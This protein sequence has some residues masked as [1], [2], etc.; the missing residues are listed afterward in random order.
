M[1]LP[2]LRL[3]LI[4]AIVAVLCAGPA[5]PPA[6]AHSGAVAIAVPATDITID[7]DLTDWPAEARWSPIDKSR[8]LD[9]PGTVLDADGQLSVAYAPSEGDLYV[10]IRVADDSWVLPE[11]STSWNSGDGCE[12][13]VDLLHKP[14][15]ERVAQFAVR[16]RIATTSDPG[17]V[18]EELFLDADAD[19]VE[20]ATGWDGERRVY[21]WRVRVVQKTD[22][23]TRLS[24][25]SVVG[26][27]AAVL[28]RDRDGSFS[29]SAWS[30]GHHRFGTASLGDVILAGPAA[31][32]GSLA[33]VAASST[34]RP[35]RRA[36]LWLEPTEAEGAWLVVAAD[37]D[38]RVHADLPVGRYRL[39]AVDPEASATPIEVAAGTAVDLGTVAIPPLRAKTVPLGPG[40][41]TDAPGHTVPAGAGQWRP[42]WRS[43]SVEDG[44]PDPT[45]TD[46]AQ[47]RAGN[48]W[49][50]TLAGV[51]RYDGLSFTTFTVRDGLPG[52]AASAVLADPQD[53]IWLSMGG[54]LNPGG[55][56]SCLANGR[57]TTYQSQDGLPGSRVLSMDQDGQG[58]LWLGMA[59]GLARLH[60]DSLSVYSWD[61]GLPMA[62]VYLV[63]RTADN[64]IWL[65][66]NGAVG[67]YDGS[68]IHLFTVQDGLPGGHVQGIA[69]TP[70]GEVWVGT[71]EG[72]ARLRGDRFVPLPRGEGSPSGFTASV[73]A[74]A[75]GSMWVGTYEGAHRHADGR[76][77][78]YSEEDGL[79]HS[80]IGAWLRDR[81]GT[82][83]MGTGFGRRTHTYA[84]G[85][86]SMRL[87]DELSSWPL[88][89][90]V[91]DMVVTEDGE[92][93][94]ATADGIWEI[95]GDTVRQLTVES[96]FTTGATRD[97]AGR[98]WFAGSNGLFRR[99]P[100][101]AWRR[102]GEGDGLPS[103]WTS[104]VV[105]D[106]RGGVWTGVSGGVAHL[107]GQLVT[108]SHRLQPG[109]DHEVCLD[110]RGRLWAAGGGAVYMLE[111]GHVQEFGLAEG[112]PGT[113]I[114]TV[115]ADSR[116]RI[117]IGTSGA[118]ALFL[119]EGR[120]RRLDAL[121]APHVIDITEDSRGH[122]WFS[123]FG[124]GAIRYDGS[125][126]QSLTKRDGLVH[127]AVQEVVE[128]PAGTYWICTEGGVTR[129][130][131]HLSPPGVRVDGATADR[132]YPGGA[133]LHLIES[134][135]VLAFSF[136]GLSFRT[137]PLQLAYQ[138]RLVGF[139]DEWRIT[140]SRRVTYPDL[141]VGAYTFEV[142]AID[143]DLVRSDE[144]ATM[145][146]T[147]VG[148]YGRLALHLGLTISL[149]AL[150]VVAAYAA[151]QRRGQRRAELALM[152]DMEEELTTAHDLQMG[153]MPEGAPQ[154]AGLAAAG[155]CEPANHVGGDFYQYYVREGKLTICLADATGH[156]MEAAIPAVMFD[157]ILHTHMERPIS[158]V[159]LFTSLNVS[160][161]RSLREHTFVCLC[162]V[163]LD[164]VNRT[165][166]LSNCGCPHPLHYRKETGEIG[167][168]EVCAYP[169][170]VRP[171][172]EY[173]AVQTSIG[174]GD[175]VVLYSDGVAEAGDA[176]SRVFGFDRT[177]EVIR[178]ACVDE[179]AP[180]EVVGRLVAE[181][182]A[183]SRGQAQGDDMTC[184]VVRIVGQSAV[185]TGAVP[186]ETSERTGA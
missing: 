84:G 137:R 42:P 31:E 35:V 124:T 169:L 17:G 139:H 36:R 99:D 178:Q 33:A 111:D 128:H 61:R 172:T 77:T 125:A 145:Q 75:D 67:R 87:G 14:G 24:P 57:C 91:F 185:S 98:G 4:S 136:S 131:P 104:S 107:D 28:D 94:L 116:G 7:G 102:F 20:V 18:S 53:R 180:D 12:L 26:L 19:D 181:V 134:Q 80:T 63:V 44:L 151:R 138:Y 69:A 140:R 74:D 160:L 58:G 159:E 64:Q 120:F 21:E 108:E 71:T 59:E 176:D 152:R 113:N 13:Y 179:L 141:S 143:R 154:M 54:P 170:G 85:G 8:S 15:N 78:L 164:L 163:E 51:A 121:D 40:T 55:G 132:A 52:T 39:R 3:S 158:M 29:Q 182:K 129:Y 112:V 30:W 115:F 173:S 110:D 157:G 150:G 155:H 10:A 117:W 95:D 89:W 135:D 45:V 103:T 47:D 106:G 49:V 133:P 41:A 127:N 149:V 76:W 177:I 153:L 1:G 100:N 65:G 22:G 86:L 56:L 46:L 81:A 186:A 184:V 161:C 68:H 105:E 123:T 162:A 16:T 43:L 142:Q 146:V 62:S 97:R 23:D 167:E 60:R 93:L 34:G 168:V 25:G 126:F 130:R 79:A 48:L 50:A 5:A 38:G 109:S 72:A 9:P 6:W 96:G 183:H 156:A 171:G 122:L 175:Y 174:A 73:F 27:D 32:W 82:L 166:C 66:G 83:W 144:P 88:D 92:A 148:D 147:V 37:P 90:P 118:G 119:D 114:W 101:G 11:G 165:M 70:G 2:F